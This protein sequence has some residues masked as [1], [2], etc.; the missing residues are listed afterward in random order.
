MDDRAAIDPL[1]GSQL[2]A[3]RVE[4]LIGIGGMGRVYKAIQPA[5]GSRVA[6][7]VLSRECSD[8]KDLVERFFAEARAINVVAHESIVNV[9]DLAT[10]PD[11]RPYIVMEFLDGTSLSNVIEYAKEHGPLPMGTVTK[12][13]IEVLDALAAAHA[14]GVIHRDLKPDNIFVSPTGRAKVL[15]FGIAK[16]QP[17]HGGKNTHT[18]SLLGTPPYMSPEQA[19]GRPI[20]TRADLYAMGII[21]FECLTLQRPFV[22]DA[23]FDLLKKHI[24][25]P[26]P[27]PRALRPDMPLELEQVIFTAL[28]KFPAQRFANARAMSAALQHATQNL[29]PAEW[30]ALPV[31]EPSRF[32]QHTPQHRSADLA[33]D[34]TESGT[35]H[36]PVEPAGGT[37]THHPNNASHPISGSTREPDRSPVAMQPTQTSGQSTSPPTISSPRNLGPWIALT[38]LIVVAGVIGVVVL[39]KHNETERKAEPAP[40]VVTAPS[41]GP[42]ELPAPPVIPETPAQPDKTH[43]AEKGHG[44]NAGKGHG[45]DDD[46]DPPDPDDLEDVIDKA[47]AS[48]GAELPPAAKAAIKKYGA[49][50]SVPPEIRKKLA[51]TIISEVATQTNSMFDVLDGKPTKLDSSLASPTKISAPPGWSDEHVDVDT[52]IDYALRTAKKLRA[53]TQITRIEIDGVFADGHAALA[54]GKH[55]QVRLR[56]A[57]KPCA[58]WVELSPDDFVVRPMT[59]NCSEV[60]VGKPKCTVKQVMKKFGQLGSD[61]TSQQVDLYFTWNPAKKTAR[62]MVAGEQIADD[63]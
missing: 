27:S 20:D 48:A 29:P 61:K 35:P 51:S 28:A 17:E 36:P 7:K 59:D 5:I 34:P 2:G 52:A 10:L 9:L 60:V 14:K 44:E 38:A 33:T 12:L 3:Y 32:P 56:E 8:R 21:L 58:M 22:A 57:G 25:E 49:W 15:D 46:E 30:G 6:I 26:P 16:L 43:V 37:L 42:T 31:G 1:I 18:G 53:D 24:E 47:M 41:P 40:V 19:A 39:S 23:L 11:G 54:A 55:V 63:C 4:S 45:D 62:W 50:K 13:V